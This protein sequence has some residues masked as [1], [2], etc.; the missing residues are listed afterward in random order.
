MTWLDIAI[1]V[2]LL[3]GL[4]LGFVRGVVTELF[5]I[6]SI[7][8][9]FFGARAWAGPF[10]AWIQHQVNWNASIC[11][12]IAYALLFLAI[13]TVLSI[14]GKLIS[15][16]L[17]AIKLGFVNRL[18][19]GL[20]GSAKWVLIVFVVVFCVDRIDQSF[21]IL[22]AQLKSQSHVYQQ[23]VVYANKAL[24]TIQTEFNKAI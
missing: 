14:I 12:V 11:D 19:G 21:H 2:P 17:K 4:V 15:K 3:I 24:S 23:T 16:L 10:S 13:A 18:L 6:L 1:L 5:T 20:F 9:G 8:G 22:N 7:V